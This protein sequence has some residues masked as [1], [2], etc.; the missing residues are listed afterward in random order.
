MRL[1]NFESQTQTAGWRG[2]SFFASLLLNLTLPG[3]YPRSTTATLAAEAVFFWQ[4]GWRYHRPTAATLSE[5]V[6]CSTGWATGRCTTPPGSFVSFLVKFG[7]NSEKTPILA[8]PRFF[9]FSLSTGG[10]GENGVRYAVPRRARGRGPRGAVP[11]W[12]R[13]WRRRREA[14]VGGA[15]D[16]AGPVALACLLTG[17]V[18]CVRR[19]RRIPAAGDEACSVAF[20]FS[21][22][23]RVCVPTQQDLYTA[24]GA[25]C[26][27]LRA[28]RRC[29]R[30]CVRLWRFC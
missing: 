12:G 26:C 28:V 17:V 23:N 10:H 16:E 3:S 15:G 19:H 25:C 21:Y 1:R 8:P 7:E 27:W 6:P 13:R 5:S 11:G 24:I 2:G 30:C 14:G 29:R 4:A 22:P 20:G 18:G 9:F